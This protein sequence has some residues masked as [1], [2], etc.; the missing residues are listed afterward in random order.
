MALTGDGTSSATV[1]DSN[2]AH[3]RVSLEEGHSTVGEHQGADHALGESQVLA[4]DEEQNQPVSAEP[5][6]TADIAPEAMFTGSETHDLEKEAG[7]ADAT[8]NILNR[9]DDPNVVSWDDNDPEN[10]FNWP[11]WRV[12]TNLV[13][14]SSM[15]FLT[16]LA[17]CT[18]LKIHWDAK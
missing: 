5:R 3:G 15:T 18:L 13:L 7:A 17:S 2:D 11:R 1:G 9:G 10:P 16:P 12:M 8:A 6:G 14:I 4:T